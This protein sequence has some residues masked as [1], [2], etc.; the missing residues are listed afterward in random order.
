[1]GTGGGGGGWAVGSEGWVPSSLS[2]G[3]EGVAVLQDAVV[4]T[5]AP[6]PQRGMRRAQVCR[7][8]WDD[9]AAVT[10]GDPWGSVPPLIVGERT[11]SSKERTKM[12]SDKNKKE[13]FLSAHWAWRVAGGRP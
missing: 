11:Y 3:W 7:R 5:T 2:G 12:F 1:M 6:R 4:N 13:N 8:E 10:P 9:L